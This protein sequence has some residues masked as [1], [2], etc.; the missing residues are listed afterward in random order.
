MAA[1]SDKDV[2]SDRQGNFM[3][4]LLLMSS[5]ILAQK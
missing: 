5:W 1:M 2:R 4:C 3:Q